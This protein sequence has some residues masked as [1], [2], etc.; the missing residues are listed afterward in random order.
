MGKPIATSIWKLSIDENGAAFPVPKYIRWLSIVMATRAI[1]ERSCCFFW[2]LQWQN[3]H[4]RFEENNI[5]QND[6][7]LYSFE[8]SLA[9]KKLSFTQTTHTTLNL[10][11]MANFFGLMALRKTRKFCIE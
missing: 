5:F 11:A 3:G 8:V 7:H 4:F 10:T 2:N 1:F 9:Q 6:G